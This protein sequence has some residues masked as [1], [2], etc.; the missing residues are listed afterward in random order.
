MP[1]CELC[2]KETQLMTAIVEGTKLN[3]CQNCGK[4]GKVLAT[5][6]IAKKVETPAATQPSETIVEN[7]A[8]LIR[9]AREKQ[10]LTQEEF[11]KNLNEKES[12][13]HKLE[14]GTYTPP[15]TLAR[16]L[17]KM[18]KITLVETEVELTT[19]SEK[20]KTGTLTIG[21]LIQLKK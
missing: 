14:N 6:R 10:G 3:V 20:R 21:D 19:T 4:Y 1:N 12:I 7:Y 5:P 9:E 13:I 8:K 16:K 18:L 2:G 15:I 11:A 17:E